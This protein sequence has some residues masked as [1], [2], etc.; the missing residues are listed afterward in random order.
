MLSSGTV[1]TGAVREQRHDKQTHTLTHER[2]GI[3]WTGLDTD[4][5]ATWPR[6]LS[7]FIIDRRKGEVYFMDLNKEALLL[8]ADKQRGRVYGIELG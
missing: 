8:H 2:A 6:K 3:W 1:L 5:E 7:V 4:G